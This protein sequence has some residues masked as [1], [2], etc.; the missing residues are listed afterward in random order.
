[1]LKLK[2]SRFLTNAAYD[3]P[4][5][6]TSRILLRIPFKERLSD[7]SKRASSERVLVSRV[8]ISKNSQ[9]SLEPR[10]DQHDLSVKRSSFVSPTDTILDFTTT[11][12][13]IGDRQS[14][15]SEFISLQNRE[16]I[17]SSVRPI[18]WA[19]HVELLR[20]RPSFA[21]NGVG[22]AGRRKRR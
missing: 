18:S 6:K 10:P 8:K 16:R 21:T 11:N 7:S 15:A 19:R 17:A 20:G 1:M 12:C 9:S 13:W 14:R 4:A 3:S 2:S 5:L 22:C